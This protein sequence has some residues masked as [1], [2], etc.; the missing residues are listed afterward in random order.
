M[1]VRSGKGPLFEKYEK[2]SGRMN[3]RKRRG[4]GSAENGKPR[5]AVDEKKGL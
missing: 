3:K 5:M 2:L 1:L 4:G